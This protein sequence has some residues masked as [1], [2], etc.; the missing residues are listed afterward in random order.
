M[1]TP[2]TT[3]AQPL[4][5]IKAH[6]EVYATRSLRRSQRWAWRLRALNGRI[7]AESGEG[8]A[9]RGRAVS[10]ALRVCRGVEVVD[11]SIGKTAAEV[12][13]VRKIQT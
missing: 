9:D 10:M 4:D 13:A 6:V 2:A 11:V 3:D 5:P 12:R 8:Y 7:V 1:T